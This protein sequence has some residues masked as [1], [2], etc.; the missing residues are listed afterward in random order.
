MFL[1]SLPLLL[2]GCLAKTVYYSDPPNSEALLRTSAF[3]L[4]RF[5]GRQAGLFRDI[6]IQEVYRI[7]NFDYLDEVSETQR[8]YTALVAAEVE[9]F[10]VRDEEEIRGNTRINLR[11]RN[12]MIQEPGQE[13]ATPRQAFEFEEI[14]FSERVM[15]RTLD[16]E[17][18]FSFLNAGSRQELYQG[19]EKISFQQSYVGEAEILAMPPADSEM[20]RLGRLLVQRM[21]DRLNPVQKN[22]TL[23]LEVGTSPLP[24]SGDTVD[25]G[26]P[27]ILQANRYAVSGDYDRALKGW[28]YVVFEPVSFGESERFTF[29]SELYTRLRQARLPQN[30]LKALL[31]L[32]GKSYSL[33]EID[34]V[35]IALLER[36]D[37]QRYS[38]IIKFY[39][40][41]SR[42]QD[43]QNLAAAHFNLGSVYRLQ[44]RW[45]L[46]A[47]HF[48]QAN[49]YQPGIKYAQAWT[50]MQIAAGSYN[51]LDNLAENTIEAAG[52]TSPPADALVQPRAASA[53]IQ[54]ASQPAEMEPTRI[55]PVELPFLSEDPEFGLEIN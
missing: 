45:P 38:A 43:G 50:D 13:I 42:P 7:P 51:P 48:A 36:Q 23:E 14:P 20:M 31:R 5:T 52:T 44:Q 46:A 30:T 8:E 6:F 2:S 12:V 19:N 32:Y 49:A 53:I 1:L 26:H 15:H 39:A 17:I 35:L 22:R 16:L 27:G 54:P 21:L 37:F 9:I 33:K 55:E 18:H 28:S 11:S 41:T 40:R 34:P 29:G 4:E 24:W 3:S 10:S 47:Y 25:L